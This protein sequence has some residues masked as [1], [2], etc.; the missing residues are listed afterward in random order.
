[1][2]EIIKCGIIGAGWWATL[3]HIPALLEHP[4]AEVIAIQKRDAVQARKVANDFHI[5]YACT[6]EEELLQIDGLQ[7]V[8]VSSSPNRHFAQARMALS[9]GKHVLIEKPMTLTTAE[10]KE[11]HALAEKH[12]LQFLISCPWHYTPHAMEAQRLI[13]TGA[14]GDVRMISILMTNPVAHLLRGT[15]SEATYGKAYVLPHQETYS[16]PTIGGGGQ[17]YA[18][19]SHVA[20]YVAF[21]CGEHATEVFARFHNDGA[22][23]DIYDTISLRMQNGA[24]VSIASTG[25]TNKDKRDYEVR[26]FGTEGI[27]FL[28]LWK[29]TMEFERMSGVRKEFPQL[30]SDSVYP[31]QAPAKNLIDSILDPTLNRSPAS[32]GVAAMEIIEGAC[33]S[34]KTGTNILVSNLMKKYGDTE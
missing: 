9:M 13:R 1:M 21:L 33:L 18:Q 22:A 26:I 20:A 10:A 12:R 24:I 23:L 29:G 31:H 3:A 4:N 19:V 34:A 16:D 25:A 8:V 27:L 2:S 14:L 7:A 32:L 28:D 6:T 17:I 11:L 15:S 5:P 30:A